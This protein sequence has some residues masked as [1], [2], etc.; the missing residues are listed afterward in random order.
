MMF[1]ARA[2]RTRLAALLLVAL[3]AGLCASLLALPARAQH[4]EEPPLRYFRIGTAAAGGTYFP[5]GGLI[6]SALSSP[7]GAR[8][9]EQGGSCGVPGLIAVAQAT[10]GSVENVRLIAAGGLEAGLCQADVAEAAF[11]GTGAFAHDSHPSLRVIAALFSEAVHVVVREPSSIAGIEQLRGRRVSLGEEFS[12]T[13]VDA[14]AVLAAF[15]LRPRDLIVSHL[16]P[17]PASDELRAG[18][19]DAFFL[20]A[21]APVPSVRELAEATRIRLLP[22]TGAAADAL[23]KAHPL[24][25]RATIPGDAYRGVAA[26]G[27]VGVGAELVVS[28]ALEE[29]LAYALTK[30]L[31]SESTRSLLEGGHRGGEEIQLKHALDGLALPLHPG[32]E[33]YYREKG[34]LH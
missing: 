8:P 12:G 11:H 21:G 25:V 14:E 9:C 32:A 28:S 1:R 26:T 24:L 29:D 33:R 2:G 7:P 31:W 18:H 22:I 20:T 13:E 10:Q 16:A 27:T 17:G 23:H 34:L 6:A 4:D 3:A 5:I 15:H 19:I 30:A